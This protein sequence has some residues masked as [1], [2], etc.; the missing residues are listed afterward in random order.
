MGLKFFF[1]II[2]G[3]GNLRR[4]RKA[5]FDNQF[6]LLKIGSFVNFDTHKNI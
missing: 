5:L 6:D 4:R 2:N 1:A 3:R